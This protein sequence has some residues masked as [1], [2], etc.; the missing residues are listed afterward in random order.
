[1]CSSPVTIKIP[2]DDNRDRAVCD[3]CGTIFY[4]N[5]KVVAGC[6]LVWDQKILLCKRATEPRSGYWTLPAGFMENY[7]TVEEGALRE[8]MEEAGAK[9]DNIKLFMLCNLPHISQVYMIYQGDLLN[10]KY[11]AGPESEEVK[12]FSKDEIP[13]S[14]LAFAVIEKTIKAYYEDIEKGKINVHFDT[15]IKK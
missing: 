8:T 12:L 10:G 14:E 11:K 1:M 4:E 2:E 6:L 15:I 7:E 3:K 13:W 5:P 9:S